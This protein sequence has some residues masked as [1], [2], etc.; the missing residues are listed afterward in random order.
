[1]LHALAEAERNIKSAVVLKPKFQ[2]AGKRYTPS[3]SLLPVLDSNAFALFFSNDYI[4]KYMNWWYCSSI[5]EPWQALM[6]T[7]TLDFH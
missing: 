6:A 5:P 3:W 4:E 2:T 1:M 7:K